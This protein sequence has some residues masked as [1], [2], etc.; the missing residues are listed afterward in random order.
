MFTNHFLTK[1]VE[2]DVKKDVFKRPICTRFPPEPNGYLHISN[3]YAIHTSYMI[4]EQFGGKFHLRFDDTNPLKEDVEYVNS[5]IEDI[6]WLGYS[7]GENIFYGSDYSSEIF[8]SALTLIK[9]GKA[10]VC[11]LSPEEMKEYRGTLTEGGTDSPNRNRSIEENIELFL[12]MKNG[13]FPTSSKVL[14]AK[15]DM[16]SPNINLRDPVLYRIIHADHY[17]TGNE[18][19]IYPMYDFAHPI[20]DAIEGVTHSLCS[21]EFK[22]HRPLYEWVLNQLDLP[23]PPKQREFGRLNLTGVVTSKRYLRELVSGSFV[24][25][26]D[27]PRL[28]TV[29]GLRRRGYTPEAIRHF[30]EEI[31]LA[32]HQTVVDMGMLEH[33]IRNDLKPKVKS[34]MAV[35]NPLKVVITNYPD[36]ESEFLPVKNNS[37][38]A[39][40]GSREVPFSNIV[41]I[42]KTDFMEVA[43]PGFKRLTLGS[44]VRLMGAY[45]IKCN[46]VVK[47]LNGE[48]IELRCT[49]DPETKSGTGYNG[50]KVKGTIHWVSAAHAL[51]V[52]VHLYN[53]LIEDDENLNDKNKTWDEKINPDSLI[54]LR[55]ALVEP[56]IKEAKLE[57][58]FQFLRHGYF[59]ID[60][61]YTIGEKLVL[62]RIV[63]LKDSW[64]K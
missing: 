16:N 34:V 51:K 1:I 32:K 52:D 3:A 57:D 33:A 23:E 21:I 56:S 37:E 53:K 9:K 17:R 19:C 6:N 24:D 36:G 44:E 54:I 27:D 40:L 43:E 4:A 14:R 42:E 31:G 60:T 11:D 62:N 63:S 8:G 38:N 26:W 5:I 22:D 47:D 25:G 18:W 28:P 30:I 46:E 29:R 35:L 41:Y 58:K 13:E 10:F 55:D 39:E 61:K 45:F 59:C 12:K 64:K 7:P 15:I 49:Y 48:I 20:Q 2:E 50:R